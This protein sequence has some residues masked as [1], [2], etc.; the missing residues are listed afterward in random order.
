MKFKD[1]YPDSRGYFDIYGGRFV[2]ET[3]M[4]I[5]IDM[6]KAYGEA[7]E[8]PR[9]HEEFNALMSEYVGRPTP[10]TF[11]G[12]LTENLNG[13]KIYLKREDLAH[14]GAHKINNAIGQALLARRMGKT[15]IIAETGAG[16]HGVATATAAAL[17]G[18]PCEI[19]M[20]TEDMRRQSLNVFRMKLLGSKV[21]EVKSGS[22][23]L[24]DAI[25]EA[26]RN[27]AFTCQDTFYIFGS[28]LGPHPF[29][30]IVR[31]FQ[32]IIG[33]EARAQIM[34]KEGRVPD[35][36][37][38][39]VGGGSNSIGL[40][41]EFLDDSSTRLIGVEA[42]GTGDSYGE[43]AARFLTGKPGVLHGTF[44]YVL[45]D[46]D[47]QISPTHSVSAGLD[48]P[49]V[50]PEHSMLR[51]LERTEYAT[52]SDD[53]TIKAF[54]VLSETEGIIPALESAHAVAHVIKIA[55]EM[56]S[57]EIILINLSGRGDKDV[58]TAMERI[59]F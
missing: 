23:T 26:M 9:F 11:A 41:Y 50:G 24:K 28:V 5:L 39:C 33:R 8:D 10:L 27:W 16:Q 59:Q 3:M 54:R 42:G 45:Q 46:D 32:R 18:M 30:M 2:P 35:A 13:A 17:F 12:R 49:S 43:H 38:A 48:Y 53:E 4:P 36:C 52:A 40:F 29:P 20:G 14:T 25:N 31:D 22:Q 21:T 51:K 19:F 44:T 1:A 15:R 47:G 57:D 37:V 34:E 56:K 6:E 58:M 55:P 7:K